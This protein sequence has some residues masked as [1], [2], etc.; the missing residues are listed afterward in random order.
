VVAEQGQMLLR[1]GQRQVVQQQVRQVRREHL[2]QRLVV[3]G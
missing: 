3:V 2:E 1:V